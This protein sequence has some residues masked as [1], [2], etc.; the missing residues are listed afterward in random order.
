MHRRGKGF[1]P[2]EEL[3]TLLG[4][5]GW[6]AVSEELHQDKTIELAMPGDTEFL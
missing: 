3:N 5:T 2:G 6:R 1:W 4:S